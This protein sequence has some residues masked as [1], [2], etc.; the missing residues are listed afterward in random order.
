MYATDNGNSEVIEK[1][2]LNLEANLPA[3]IARREIPHYLGGIISV[4]ILA[5]L[6]EDGPPYFL[7]NKHA[8]YEKESFLQWLKSRIKK[9]R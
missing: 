6:G 8:T 9:A 1:A 5:N 3:I 2:L 4:G 7:V